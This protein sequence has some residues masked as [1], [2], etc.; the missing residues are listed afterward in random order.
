MQTRVLFVTVWLLCFGNFQGGAV[1]AD[2]PNVAGLDEKFVVTHA[3]GEDFLVPARPGTDTDLLG[4]GFTRDLRTMDS[5]GKKIA[6]VYKGKLSSKATDGFASSWREVDDDME[7][8][9]SAGFFGVKAAA[10]A[11]THDR[12][13]ILT[14]YQIDKVVKID[15]SAEIPETQADLVPVEI[16]YGWSLNYLFRGQTSGQELSAS[17][18]MLVADASF[19]AKLKNKNITSEF[20]ASGLK[21][22]ESGELPIV[23]QPKDIT[24]YFSPSSQAQ[25]IL[26]KYQSVHPIKS[27]LIGGA[28]TNANQAAGGNGGASEDWVARAKSVLADYFR[29]SAASIASQIQAIAHP[30]GDS[31]QISSLRVENSA[32]GIC[33]TVVCKWFT[34]GAAWSTRIPH[35]TTVEWEITPAGSGEI[36][37]IDKGADAAA[38]PAVLRLKAYFANTVWGEIADSVSHD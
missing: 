18:Q 26:I 16:W 23:M 30:N 32:N 19:Q 9:L 10:S 37:V 21:Q 3:A 22:K 36:R 15:S 29:K 6:V 24:K 1:A 4:K 14:V 38:L 31:P 20:R 13:A 34:H 2:G 12:F 17:L 5:N 8:G 11:N 35:D 7:F 25:P 27:A 33:V 28:R